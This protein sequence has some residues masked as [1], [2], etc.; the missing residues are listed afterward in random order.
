MTPHLTAPS[1]ATITAAGAG[2]T[3]IAPALA[4]L[5]PSAPPA[6]SSLGF[7]PDYAL[8][9]AVSSPAASPSASGWMV[10]GEIASP[11]SASSSSPTAASAAAFPTSGPI[12]LSPSAP[13]TRAPAA[14]GFA[15]VKQLSFPVASEGEQKAALTTSADLAKAECKLIP[16]EADMSNPQ[17]E[18]WRVEEAFKA[19]L[20]NNLEVRSAFLC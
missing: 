3:A 10:S 15:S 8:S 14:A 9:A 5:E 20:A 4:A 17:A 6:Y 1:L 2:A 12:A 7:E 19:S 18:F 13:S 16:L 11:S